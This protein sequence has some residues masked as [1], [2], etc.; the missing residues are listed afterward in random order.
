M[1]EQKRAT[2]ASSDRR[3]L[4]GFLLR[5]VPSATLPMLLSLLFIGS[6]V[7]LAAQETADVPMAD[8]VDLSDYWV[9]GQGPETTWSYRFGH[10]PVGFVDRFL[11]DQKVF[12]G[13]KWYQRERTYS[14]GGRDTVLYR[15]TDEGLFH[16]IPAAN[17][18]TP[19]MTIPRNGLLGQ[20]WMESDRTW[21]YTIAGIGV[22][23][24]SKSM[25]F[26]DLLMIRATELRPKE[27][28]APKV[29]DLY[30]ARDVGMVAAVADSVA[31]IQIVATNGLDSDLRSN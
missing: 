11:S 2:E 12:G 23:L 1:Q 18:A 22:S 15:E 26:V 31:F 21:D 13:V 6:A 17:K 4:Q 14:N 8:S 28:A 30:F 29:F 20:T 27:G 3:T 25:N 9:M 7:P 24:E 5:A 19:S 16:I 10:A